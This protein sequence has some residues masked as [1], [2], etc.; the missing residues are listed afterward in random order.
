MSGG[1]AGAALLRAGVRGETAG[2]SQARRLRRML[3]ERR[4][5]TRPS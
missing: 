1:V 2:L 5:P 3:R 4:A